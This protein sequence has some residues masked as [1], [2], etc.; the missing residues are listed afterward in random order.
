MPSNVV[1]LRPETYNRVKRLA[2]QQDLAMQEVIAQG[3]D[4]LERLEFARGFQEDFASMRRDSS[5]W[6]LQQDEHDLW[7]ST[8]SDGIGQ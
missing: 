4:A 8:L 2:Q 6:N 5:A 1:K 3:I 7:D